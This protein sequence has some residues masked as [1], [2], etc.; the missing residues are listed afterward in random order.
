M[1]KELLEKICEAVDKGHSRDTEKLIS[2]AL[3][4]GI[5]ARTIIRDAMVPAMKSAGDRYEEEGSDIISIL[6]AARSM[7][8]GLN[9]LEPFMNE[10]SDMHVGTAILGTIEGDLHE[11]GKNLVNMMMQSEGFEVIDLGVD[12]NGKQFIRAI[13][14]HPEAKFVCISSL[15]TT[16]ESA[17]RQVVKQ[18][19]KEDKKH[20]LTIMVGG[21]CVTE[22]LAREIGADIFTEN[23]VTAAETARRV[24]LEKG[25]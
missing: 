9:V 8:K 1:G 23:A 14:E 17:L 18:I 20:E 2:E 10:T 12:I 4:S 11:V 6:A 22:K 15:L 13:R 21:G 16:S 19:R 3:S 7:Q 24:A 5:G 25:V